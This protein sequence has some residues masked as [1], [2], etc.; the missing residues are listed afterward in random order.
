MPASGSLEVGVL[1]NEKPEEAE[2]LRYS[3]FLAQVGSDE[4]TSMEPPQ[5]KDS[6]VILVN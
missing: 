1:I 5:P 4:K 3:G 6:I 2:E